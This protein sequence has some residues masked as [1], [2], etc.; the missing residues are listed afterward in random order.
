M[1]FIQNQIGLV[2]SG[3]YIW[4][5]NSGT[6]VNFSATTSYQEMTSLGTNFTLAPISPDF[7]MSTDGRLK[8]SRL[9]ETTRY[10]LHK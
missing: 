4:M 1:A 10:L 5:S 3:G 8:F 6:V 2:G 9:Y 7:A